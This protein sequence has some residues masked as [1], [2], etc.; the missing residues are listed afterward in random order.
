MSKGRR[1]WTGMI[2]LGDESDQPAPPF[3]GAGWLAS[4]AAQCSLPSAVYRGKEVVISANTWIAAQRAL[5][6]IQGCHQLLLGEPPVFPIHL[7]AHNEKEPN[8]TCGKAP[9]Q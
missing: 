7:L 3:A 2:A 8:V 6:L 9:V 4:L 5:D 1:F